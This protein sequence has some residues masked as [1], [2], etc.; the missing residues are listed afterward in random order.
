[1]TEEKRIY[2]VSSQKEIYVEGQK[3]YVD[4]S[5]Q[6]SAAQGVKGDD[7]YVRY[8]AIDSTQ[9]NDLLTAEVAFVGSMR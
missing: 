1:M 6:Y 8:D 3:D 2:I 9:S 5:R 7:Y 4:P